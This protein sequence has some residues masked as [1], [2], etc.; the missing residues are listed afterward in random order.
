M[1]E[2]DPD[3]RPETSDR[4]PSFGYGQR[5]PIE[6]P[7][8]QE[9][10]AAL[11][12]RLSDPAAFHQSIHDTSLWLHAVLQE[13]VAGME[14]VEVRKATRKSLEAVASM[15]EK[16]ARALENLPPESRVLLA[17]RLNLHTRADFTAQLKNLADLHA[18]ASE[19]GKFFYVGRGKP[20]DPHAKAAASSLAEAWQEQTGSRPTV[21]TNPT[22][23]SKSGKFLQL[24]D[25]IVT[26]V[27]RI[28]GLKPPSAQRLAHEILYFKTSE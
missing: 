1:T 7:E 2:H 11:L 27:Y 12:P 8:E 3:A 24:I 15:A 5:L 16:T 9:K 28:N 13:R 20:S 25:A 22:D 14:N 26:P 6:N 10:V 17:K 19:A 18:S 23:G 21:T 4:P